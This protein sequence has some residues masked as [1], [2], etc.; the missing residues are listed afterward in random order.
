MSNSQE[1]GEEDLQGTRHPKPSLALHLTPLMD[2][3]LENFG[4]L[5]MASSSRMYWEGS[6]ETELKTGL[7]K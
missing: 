4:Y 6:Q 2:G 3:V 5:G 7:D 1:T